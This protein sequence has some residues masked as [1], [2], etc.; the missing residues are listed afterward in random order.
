MKTNYFILYTH[1]L[2]T[3]NNYIV[4]L[5]TNSIILFVYSFIRKIKQ[6]VYVYNNTTG[7]QSFNNYYTIFLFYDATLAFFKFI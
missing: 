1:N 4:Q 7:A 5:N 3:Y 6:L 2:Y